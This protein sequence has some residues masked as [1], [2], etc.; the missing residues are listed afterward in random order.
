MDVLIGFISEVTG[1][2]RG[3]SKHYRRYNLL[4]SNNDSI[5]GWIFSSTTI[6][7]TY[8]GNILLEAS[9]NNL[10]VRLQGKLSTETGNT[11]FSFL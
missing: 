8:A 6:E 11:K 1:E 5:N 9:Q 2:K 4:T 10:P 3:P 7:Q